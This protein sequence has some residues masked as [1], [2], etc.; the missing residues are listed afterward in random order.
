MN[1]TTVLSLKTLFLPS[2]KL[3]ISYNKRKHLQGW[4][5]LLI[6]IGL[7]NVNYL[8]KY[9]DWLLGRLVLRGID[10]NDRKNK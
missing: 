4:T 7:S 8:E 3:Q 5:K 6:E 10:S 2:S 9:I 1:K